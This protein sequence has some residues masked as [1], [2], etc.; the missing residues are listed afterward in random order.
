MIVKIL[1]LGFLD[2]WWKWGW[3]IGFSFDLGVVVSCWV[4][5]LWD[6]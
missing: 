2:L 4:S 3:W 1:L 6:G 5:D